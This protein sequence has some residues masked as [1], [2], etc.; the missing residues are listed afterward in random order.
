[1]DFGLGNSLR[2][3]GR[4]YAHVY[5]RTTSV[6]DGVKI[7]PT[8]RSGST[9]APESGSPG[10]SAMHIGTQWQVREAARHACA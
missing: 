2:R 4:A 7:L 3:R 5:L 6:Y 1:M 9:R 8:F 10:I